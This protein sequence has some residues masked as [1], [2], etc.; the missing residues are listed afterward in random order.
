MKNKP[1]SFHTPADYL[2]MIK[3]IAYGRANGQ[4]YFG[5]SIQ[6]EEDIISVLTEIVERSMS[7][8]YQIGYTLGVAD[9]QKY[10]KI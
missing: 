9:G 2:P 8:S 10:N 7:E 1:F 6:D 3:D 5:G 4:N